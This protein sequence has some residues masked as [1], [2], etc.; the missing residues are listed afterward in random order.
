MIV[1]VVFVVVV[2]MTGVGGRPEVI[3]E[4]TNEQDLDRA[5]WKVLK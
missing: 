1:I 5:V 4:G 2:S 3:I